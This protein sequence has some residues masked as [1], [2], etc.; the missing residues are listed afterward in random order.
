MRRVTRTE[1]DGRITVIADRFQGKP[2]NSPNDVVVKSDG[3]VWFTD[4]DYGLRQNLPG[5]PRDQAKD[6]VFRVD[7]NGEITV[8]ADD[9]VKPNGLCFSPDERVLYIVDSAVTD[10]PDLPSHIRRFEVDG[11]GRVSGGD[12]FATTVGVPD[13]LRVDTDGNVWTSAGPG[14]NVY[15]PSGDWLGRIDFPQDVTNV[16]FGGDSRQRLFATSGP[17]LYCIDV[18]ARGAQR[19]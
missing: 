15:A 8:V 12:V 18:N 14:V 1:L 9:F 6:N 7:R 4:P 16:T 11:T 5:T 10:G 19:P 3:S 13:G 17:G 2:L